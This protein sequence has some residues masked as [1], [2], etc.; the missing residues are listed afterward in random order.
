MLII[1]TAW[2]LTRGMILWAEDGVRPAALPTRERSRRGGGTA[3]EHPYAA[4]SAELS[5]ALATLGVRCANGPEPGHADILLPSRSAGPLP[6]PQLLRDQDDQPTARGAISWRAW[7]TPCLE[8]TAWQAAEICRDL[9]AAPTGTARPGPELA[10]FVRA[11]LLVEELVLRGRFLPAIVRV[12]DSWHA[13]WQPLMRDP[14]DRRRIAALVTALPPACRAVLEGG[15]GWEAVPTA[16]TVVRDLLWSLTDAAVAA[17]AELFEGELP[18]VPRGKTPAKKLLQAAHAWLA[19]LV[20][21]DGDIESRGDLAGLAERLEVW[22][23][24]IG[25]STTVRTCFRLSEPE[26]GDGDGDDECWHLDLLV[27][28][29]EDPSLQVHMADLW[30]DGVAALEL[31]HAPGHDP[32]ERVLADLGRAARLWPGLDAALRTARPAGL[33]LPT[34]SAWSFLNDTAPQLEAAGFGVMIPPWWR[35]RTA[36][37]G[38]RLEVREPGKDDGSGLFGTDGL[39]AWDATLAL[40]DQTIDE[41][42]LRRLAAAK[43]PLVRLRGRWV[44]LRPEDI[45]R[46]LA[47]FRKGPPQG[48]DSVAGLLRLALGL[49]E[50]PASLPVQVVEASGPLGA[51]LRGTGELTAEP[52]PTPPGFGGVLRPYQERGLGWLRF[53]GELGL[54]ACLADD[55]GL[56]KTI[57]ILAL[58]VGE[59]LEGERPGPTLVVCPL[60]V[61][62]NWRDEAT[63]FAPDLV[64]HL[65]HGPRRLRGEALIAQVR[66]CDLIITTYAM[67][68]RDR[69]QL[70]GVAWHRLVVDEAQNIK[71]SGAQQTQVIRAIPA[72]HRVA[73]TGTPVENRLSELWSIMH[74]SNPGLLGTAADFQR[75][76]ALPVER[77]RDPVRTALLRKITG[78]FVLRR[79]KT[80]PNV[81]DDLPEKTEIKVHCHLTREQATLY[82]AVVDDMLT[83]IEQSEGIERRGLVLATLT[84]LKQV[85]NHPAQLLAD[86]SRIEGRS[87]KLARLEETADE[88]LAAGSRALIFTQYAELG[89]M[90]KARLQERFGQEVLFLHGGITRTRRA[91]MIQRFQTGEGPSLFLLSL[92]AGGTGLNLTAANHVIHFDR[93]WNPAVEDQATDRAFRIGQ[94]RNVLVHKYVCSGTLEDRID[95]L[96]ERKRE[97]AGAVVGTGEAWLTELST[98][99]L[100]DMIRLS[101]SAVAEG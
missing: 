75:R 7:R 72:R 43:V 5:R 80:D 39:C 44:E 46:A 94:R 3:A 29:S 98:K 76:F 59:R 86:G 30:R 16:A 96:I 36:R 42:E 18:A 93:W 50:G 28:D 6:S 38:L 90:L 10:V 33:V 66:D 22:G 84:K 64:V 65:H 87:G 78:P 73:L 99:A 97:L 2:S 23:T 8:A 95:T 60:S 67:A 34:D 58:M 56:G 68:L 85:C 20:C 92:K 14:E 62:D 37:L 24:P 83:R 19:A 21:G 54:G 25:A 89:R 61:A 82:R 45:Q 12:E 11:S 79:L 69:A 15:G 49:D 26:Y 4:T 31:F 13:R 32:E 55:M 100:R 9:A 35:K 70:G 57:Q 48:Q 51:L 40:G 53:L 17:R 77:D 81:V 71:N 88:L 74:F 101:A 63:R 91:E 47:A 41:D 52:A 1:H 27:Q